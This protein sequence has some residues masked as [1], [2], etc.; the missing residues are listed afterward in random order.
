MPKI[1]KDR[2]VFLLGKLYQVLNSK[3]KFEI[4]LIILTIVING[5]L[6]IFSIGSLVPVLITLISSPTQAKNILIDY[7]LYGKLWLTSSNS[8]LIISLLF[9]GLIILSNLLK[10][11]SLRLICETTSK[12]LAT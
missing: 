10:I 3:R 11:L 8:T 12:L 7:N 6:E 5:L 1:K 9:L 4:K 2:T